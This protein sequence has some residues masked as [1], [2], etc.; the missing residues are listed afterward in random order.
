MY[1]H[2]GD[3]KWGQN[4]KRILTELGV[5]FVSEDIELGC[6]F[7][8]LINKNFDA[9]IIT[10]SSVNHF[11]ILRECINLNIPVFCEKPVCLTKEQAEALR[12]LNRNFSPLFMA[13][14]QLLFDKSIQIVAEKKDTV[15]M[16]S[17]R[18]GAIPRTEGAVLSL[19]VHDIALAHF[20]FG[21][22]SFTCVEAQGNNHTCKITLMADITKPSPDIRYCEIFVQ[23]IA[24]V[25]LR[26]LSVLSHS[27][28]VERFCPDNWNRGDLL[29]DSLSHFVDCVESGKQP[30]YNSLRECCNVMDTVFKVI[31][32]MQE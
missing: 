28:A 2:L 5:R 10:T 29:K 12:E 20:L 9:V 26:H 19:A 23:S 1:L 15:Y 11:P 3:G 6:R 30:A 24:P 31:E 22:D 27:G 7:H 18:A 4:H 14:H 17:I 16:N 25:R 21:V 32:R 8:E 13:G